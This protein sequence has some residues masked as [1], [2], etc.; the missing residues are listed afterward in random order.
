[1][2]HHLKD[3]DELVLFTK[4]Y[5]GDQIKDDMMCGICSTYGEIQKFI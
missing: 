5:Y 4:Y 2:A 3:A 1:M